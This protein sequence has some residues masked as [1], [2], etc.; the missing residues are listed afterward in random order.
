M[1]HRTP[2]TD[3]TTSSRPS[4]LRLRVGVAL[5]LLWWLPFWALAPYL[6]HSLSG[7]SNP[8]SVGAVTT[9]IVVVQTVVGLLGFWVAGRQ[10]KAIV[11][12]STKKRAL[13]AI[14]SI[15]LHGEIAELDTVGTASGEERQPPAKPDGPSERAAG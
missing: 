1:R 4:P 6:T 2:T 8:P 9:V 14:W 15:F 12:G 13:R 11:Q 7:L 10:V 3:D 5:I